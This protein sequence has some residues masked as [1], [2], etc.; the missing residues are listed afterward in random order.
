M[1]YFSIRFPDLDQVTAIIHRFHRS[2]YVNVKKECIKII[3][4]REGKQKGMTMECGRSG[5][6]SV[7]VVA[8]AF[9]SVVCSLTIDA[10]S[11][12]LHAILI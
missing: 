1:L 8:I 11:L 3:M 7:R 5:S 2:P 9:C 6:C 10:S 12:K 4:C